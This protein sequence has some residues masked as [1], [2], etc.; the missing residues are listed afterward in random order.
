[1]D[2]KP[3]P[4]SGDVDLA[5][6]ARFL[7]ALTG[8][9]DPV[10]TFQTFDDDDKRKSR[11]LVRVIHA[12]LGDCCGDLY[13]LNNE[14]AGV[15][16]TVNRTDLK[17]REAENVVALRALFIDH[18]WKD[19]DLLQAI[20]LP[21][22]IVVASGNGRHYYW[23]LIDGEA[24]DRFTD[25]Q[26]R[27][28]AFYGSD[29]KPKDL[30]RVM[31]LPG[32]F[33]RK[34]EPKLS[35][36]EWADPALVYTIDEVAA[37][38]PVVDPA[39]PPPAPAPPPVAPRQH[40]DA[41]ERVRRCRAYL[42]KRDPAIEGRG[43][44][45]WTLETAMIGGDFDLSDAEFWPLLCEWNARCLP[46]WDEAELRAKLENANKY[47][48]NPRGCRL[49]QEGRTKKV[50][51]FCAPKNSGVVET[52]G[53]GAAGKVDPETA[54]DAPAGAAA[55]AASDADAPSPEANL[56]AT[57]RAE[58]AGST[59]T[60]AV[61]DSIATVDS[62][63]AR[64]ELLADVCR[65][66]KVSKKVAR[67]HVQRRLAAARNTQISIPA[68]YGLTIDTTRWYISDAGVFPVKPKDGVY[69][70]DDR[71]PVSTRPIWPDR[72]GRDRATGSLFVRIV[73]ETPESK[74]IRHEWINAR[75]LSDREALRGL[76]GAPISLG[77]IGALSDWLVDASA[78]V[79]G[80][81]L[82]LTSRMGWIGED[83]QWSA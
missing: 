20:A 61:L 16:V 75:A 40:H 12:R 10:V 64:D 45:Q 53:S 5:M 36:L 23:R 56:I 72:L 54:F 3:M 11:R 7:T 59:A 14:G 49:E 66:R 37:C 25:A 67:S 19:G 69:Q 47:R 63:V 70:V 79:S 55:D 27:L 1:M 62:V 46:P 73:W 52:P 9:D 39:E 21:P 57:I 41:D 28:I 26:R 13:D 38:H 51:D 29:R 81:P 68:R 30:P 22:S 8:E 60:E 82:E 35:V 44:D 50:G 4:L 71:Q 48:K 65:R 34:A 18:D 77:R 31:R 17:G 58:I 83:W 2:P 74:A 33:H 78:G 24:L 76:D 32:F 42:S 80:E 6:A 43:G 15:F